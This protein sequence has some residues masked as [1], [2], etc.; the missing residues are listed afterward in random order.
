MAVPCFQGTAVKPETAR[1][2]KTR[3]ESG[4]QLFQHGLTHASTP[5]YQ[6]G[7]RFW[8]PHLAGGE[9]EF[10]GLTR[11]EKIRRFRLGAKIF[12]DHGIKPVG[13]TAPAWFGTLPLQEARNS[14]LRWLDERFGIRYVEGGQW[15]FAPPLTFTSLQAGPPMAYGGKLW[16]T[17]LKTQAF[18]RISL[19]P[20]DCGYEGVKRA[21][22][23]FLE[24]GVPTSYGD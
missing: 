7:G 15:K 19:H 9:A 24:I 14:G 1:W 11:I 6:R 17:F 10:A 18:L 4:D 5:P 2:I 23:S 16:Q 22:Q 8:A 13:F 12:A 20:G 21:V 3:I